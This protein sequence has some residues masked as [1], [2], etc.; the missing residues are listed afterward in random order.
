MASHDALRLAIIFKVQCID[1][2]FEIVLIYVM[3]PESF[4]F[5][6]LANTKSTTDR[7]PESHPVEPLL[8]I[9]T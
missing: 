5:N 6:T 2:T 7:T 3:V 8:L 4:I 9:K 1:L